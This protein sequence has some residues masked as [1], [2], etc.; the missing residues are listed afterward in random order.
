MS[1]RQVF[2]YM[3][4][5]EGEKVVDHGPFV[6]PDRRGSLFKAWLVTVTVG[7]RSEE[8]KLDMAWVTRRGKED[9]TIAMTALVKRALDRLR[10]AERLAKKH[11]DNGEGRMFDDV[12]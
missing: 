1:D 2:G 8:V 11:P 5:R 9:A 7:E 10:R 3:P 12:V 4:L 6:S